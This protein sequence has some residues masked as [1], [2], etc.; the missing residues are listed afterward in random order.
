M[1]FHVFS[2]PIFLHLLYFA[3]FYL[4]AIAFD[5][6][7]RAALWRLIDYDGTARKIVR[8]IKAFCHH[9][10]A[11][12]CVYGEIKKFLKSLRTNVK[13]AS[14]PS[15]LASFK[16]CTSQS[17]VS[18]I[19]NA[20]IILFAGEGMQKVLEMCRQLQQKSDQ[21][22]CVLGRIPI[23]IHH[24]GLRKCQTLNI[25]DPLLDHAKRSSER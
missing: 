1:F 6:A 2:S 10:S 22:R 8:I 3:L 23:F 24:Q 18:Q 9:K 14:F 19:L 7:Y 15:C 20:L 5:P 12:I 25:L 11:Q 21:N 16:R 17:R 13:A 4:F